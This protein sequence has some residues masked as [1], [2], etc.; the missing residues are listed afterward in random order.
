M[1]IVSRHA[2]RVLGITACFALAA[3][4]GCADPAA[5]AAVALYS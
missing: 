2:G 3:L 4:P 1:E 5:S